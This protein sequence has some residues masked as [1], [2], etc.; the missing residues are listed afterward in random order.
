MAGL[1]HVLAEYLTSE[2]HALQVHANDAIEFIFGDVEK[3]R[4][5]VDAGAV[6]DDVDAAGTAEH[7]VEQRLDFRFA[8]RFGGL[9]PRAS[10]RRVD[11]CDP[12]IGL[13]LVASDDH[14]LGACPCKPFGH[15]A[16]QLAGAADDDRD[17]VA[18]REE[19]CSG[20]QLGSTRAPYSTFIPRPVRV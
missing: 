2:E 11:P 16:A 4:S 3:R 17:L 8:R 19:R 14:G 20:I 15:G 10:A 6:D 18:K 13:V 1:D 7:S 12:R 5:G 9:K